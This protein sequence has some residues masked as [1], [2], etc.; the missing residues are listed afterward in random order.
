[1]IIISRTVASKIFKAHRA[2]STAGGGLDK[3]KEA[4]HYSGLST[5]TKRKLLRL[6][7]S[8]DAARRQTPFNTHGT[9]PLHPNDRQ[10]ISHPGFLACHHFWLHEATGICLS[11]THFYNANRGMY[12]YEV[13]N[14]LTNPVLQ[15]CYAAPNAVVIKGIFQVD[16]NRFL[17]A[18]GQKPQLFTLT[19]GEPTNG[20]MTASLKIENFH[21]SLMIHSNETLASFGQRLTNEMFR[22]IFKNQRPLFKYPSNRKLGLFEDYVTETNGD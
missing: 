11:Q 16:S 6:T 8:P 20:A 10:S 15:V 3:E 12:Y 17:S 19:I 7:P 5:R 18:F 4:G 22:P 21:E 2:S 13:V 1:M 9:L 14:E